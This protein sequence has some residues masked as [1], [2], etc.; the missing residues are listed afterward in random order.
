[1]LRKERFGVPPSGG[2]VQH[3]LKAELHNSSARRRSTNHHET[4]P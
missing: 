4:F 1:M 3:R 2:Q